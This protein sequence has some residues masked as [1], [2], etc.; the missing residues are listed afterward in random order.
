[1]VSAELLARLEL[2]CRELVRDL[3]Q[4]K[5][6][7]DSAYAR[8][9]GGLNVILA[10]DM[11][12]LPPPRGTF[13]GDVPW[14]WL[15]Q[16]KTKK[17]AHT[18]HGQELV[19]GTSPNGIHGMTELVE[20]ER[21]RDTWLQTLQNEVRNGVLTQTNHEFLHG[22]ATRVPGSWN[23]HNLECGQAGCQKLLAEQASPEKIQSL[24]CN[25][26]SAERRS[27]ARVADKATRA[28]EKFAK[29]KA[30]FATNAV[31]YHVNKLRAKAWAAET[32]QVLHHAI[33]KDRISSIALRE[34]PDLGKEKLTWLQRHDQD[35]GSLYGV[36]PLCLGMPV[37]ATDHLDRNRGILRGC[38][39]EVVG[40]VWSADASEGARQEATQI[41]NELPSCI[42]VRFKTKATWRVEGLDEDNVFPVMPQKKPWH[43]DKGRRRPLLRI[44]RKQFPLSPGF[45]TT[46]HAAQ[47]QTY[48]EGA[49]VDMH[50]GD[51]GD[52]L[53]AYI[54]LTRVKDRHGLFVYRPFPAGPFQKG[55]KVG[56][57]LLLRFWAGENLDWS[58]LRAKYRDEKHC[59]ECNESKPASAFTVGRWKRED[60]RRVC[61]E[62]ISRHIDACEPWQCMACAAWKEEGSFVEQRAGPK[63]TF[64]RICQACEKTEL[65]GGC[66]ERKPKTSFSAGAWKQAR[67]GARMCLNC[68]CK[69]RG[70]RT[71]SVCATQKAKECFQLWMLKHTSFKGDQICDNCSRRPLAR[72]IVR[73]ALDRVAATQAKA[74]AEKRARVVAIVREEIAARKRKRDEN[75]DVAQPAPPP[76][77][78]GREQSTDMPKDCADAREE[79]RKKVFPIRLSLMS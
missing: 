14:E 28:T 56:R 43:L 49:V 7:K 16:C 60:A 35:C 18:I 32:G 72:G 68:S 19:W 40:W 57:E 5:Y 63:C 47:G 6:A 76:K 64:Y 75:L 17:V 67:G 27:K 13:L 79:S 29:A 59:K 74:V 15:T 37:A 3:A 42:L 45:A 24:E 65:C 38:S 33:A 54:A 8:P 25:V 61:K 41:W 52:P 2:R 44:T 71:C 11:W 78:Q 36:L 66:K 58:A 21:T 30:I 4:S 22:F 53:T 31:K 20:C 55:A 12:Q 34:K 46:A 1:M 77:E 51:A 73:K 69:A 50:I 9:F 48:A 39:G 23:G 10:G 70:F 62:C 26:C